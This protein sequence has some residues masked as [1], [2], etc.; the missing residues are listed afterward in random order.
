[1]KRL[2][3]FVLIL[4]MLPSFS[5]AASKATLPDFK[6][7]SRN[8]LELKETEKKDYLTMEKF[9]GSQS[10]IISLAK[11]YVELLTSKYDLDMIANFQIDYG[12][13]D[14]VNYALVYDG[15]ASMGSFNIFS[16]EHN[17][18]CENCQVF[19]Q[20]NIVSSGNATLWVYF[21]PEFNYK[22]TGDRYGGSSN[23][24]A[25]A[26]ATPKPGKKTTA[27]P[28]SRPSTTSRCTTCGGDGQVER[29]CSSCGGDGERDCMSC[30]GKGYNN[31]SGCYGSGER[32]CGSCYGTGKNGS[33]R[34]SSCSG[35]GYKDCSSCSGG[36]QRCSACSGSGDRN[37]SS[38]SG[39][40]TKSSTC[41]SCGGDGR[42]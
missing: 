14:R 17:W 4:C 28:T 33:K 21:R 34:C 22:D 37:C 7:Y 15:S 11:A 12:S 18:R 13:H 8:Q 25:K 10:L 31:C 36:K 30:S 5:L 3:A 29:S 38:C 19:L 20:Y 1:M 26:T 24:N 23:S 40:G 16:D 39:R 9:S 32:R 41:T 6:S 27:A 42:R 35:R 2:L